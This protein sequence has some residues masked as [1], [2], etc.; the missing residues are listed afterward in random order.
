MM[1][2]TSSRGSGQTSRLITAMLANRSMQTTPSGDAA[3]FSHAAN[4]FPS[5]Y[6]SG[7]GHSS[8]NG[9]QFN[10][11]IFATNSSY[12][13]DFE[14]SKSATSGT[15]QGGNP[16][17]HVSDSGYR[18]YDD[19]AGYGSGGYIPSRKQREFIP[20]NKKDDGYW[21]KRRK[22]NEAARRSR[23][24]RRFHDMALEN[25][26]LDLTKDNCKLR[27]EL[28]LI[29]KKFGLPQDDVFNGD[30]TVPKR[31]NSMSVS[32]TSQS[33]ARS[34]QLAELPVR[35]PNAPPPQSPQSTRVKHASGSYSSAAYSSYG[36]PPMQSSTQSESFLTRAHGDSEFLKSHSG[37][38][39]AQYP[40]LM[41][42]VKDDS[43]Q[44]PS[45]IDDQVRPLYSSTMPPNRISP[46]GPSLPVSAPKSY[47]IPTTD[48]TSSDSNDES[49]YFE[50]VQEQPLSLVKKRPS[51]ENE[52]SE[53]MSNASSRASNSPNSSTTL[54][55]K[56]RHKLP[57][58]GSHSPP[59]PPK[60]TNP[61][62][63]STGLAQLSEIAL[64]Q[65]GFAF[66][67]YDDSQSQDEMDAYKSRSRSGSN[68]RALFDVKYVERRRRNNEAARKCRENRKH[69]TKIREVKSGY[70][71]NE[72]GKLKEELMSLQDEMRELRGM[73]EKKR[74]TK[75]DAIDV[76]K[77]ADC[78]KDNK[79]DIEII[80]ASG[81]M[82]KDIKDENGK[83]DQD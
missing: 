69:L 20:E 78:A 25:K 35:Y 62:S 16:A 47:W 55:L 76:E 23:E 61:F 77:N 56:L 36:A 7:M 70:L 27:N 83:M 18:S 13:D 82:N 39:D 74:K 15:T 46:S 22:N 65:S 54:P 43:H 73:L 17:P 3:A 52:S 40:Y 28:T 24:K 21:E 34:S 6:P 44:Y 58:D 33:L 51:T 19:E 59:T 32:S 48:L 63:Y 11:R 45:R 57:H 64:S 72:N 12:G 38:Y 1:L 80:S 29:K 10:S 9:S 30:E 42:S 81:V 66:G 68:P 2:D 71:E 67:S 31:S 5:S 41:K 75:G 60:A 4:A 79:D 26:I 8:S 14:P 53:D 50:G 49:E 37:Q